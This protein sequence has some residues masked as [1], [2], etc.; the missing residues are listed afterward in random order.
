MIVEDLDNLD[1]DERRNFELLLRLVDLL[2]DLEDLE[3][4]IEF[5]SLEARQILE[6]A[7]Q[8]VRRMTSIRYIV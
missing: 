6:E 5:M 1:L 2:K 7:S 4:S 3:G 8:Y